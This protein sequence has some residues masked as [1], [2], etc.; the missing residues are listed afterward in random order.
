MSATFWLMFE[1]QSYMRARAGSPRPPGSQLMRALRSHNPRHLS[2]LAR[3][4][5]PASICWPSPN[6]G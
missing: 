6:D 2:A 5:E 1:T 3:A 4:I